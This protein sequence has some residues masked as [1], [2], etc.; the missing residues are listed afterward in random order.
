M[1]DEL[2]LGLVVIGQTPRPALTAELQKVMLSSRR[3]VQ[4]GALDNLTRVQIEAAK[5]KNAMDTLF[6][7]LPDGHGVTVSTG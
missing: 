2:A 7:T 3:I 4:V 1:A 6:T 5:P